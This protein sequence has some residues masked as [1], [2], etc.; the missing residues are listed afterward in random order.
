MNLN[1]FTHIYLL[2]IGGIGMS[3]LARYFMANNKI[4]AGYDRT[5]TPLTELLESEGA[6]IH[7]EDNINHISPDFLNTKD[8][9]IIYTPAIP[10]GH[11]EFN[12]FKKQKFILLKRS[13]V[14]G[15]ISRD[16][17]CIAIAGTHGKTTV[18]SMTAHILHQGKMGCNAFLGGIASNYNS[19]L[20][21]N[22]NSPNLVIEADE[23]DRS[24]LQLSPNLAVITSMDADHL[25]IYSD[26]KGLKKSFQEFADLI[27]PKGKLLIRKG[28]ENEIQTELNVY[29]Y[30][31]EDS[32]ADFRITD[33]RLIEGIYHFTIWGPSLR[34]EQVQLGMP[35]KLN[36]ENALAAA[37]LAYL[38]K[39]DSEV[40]KS[41]LASF[42]GVK[43]RMEYIIKRND[44][45]YL[46]DYA[47]HPEE[48]KASIQS[49]K[50][51]FPDKKVIGIFQPHLYSRT[52][53]F[54]DGFAESLAL[55]DQLILLEIYP[56]REEAIPGIN[57]Q[58]LL[59]KIPMK[60]KVL[61]QKDELI[62]YLKGT[63]PQVILSLG[64]G[65]IDRL[66]DN[67]KGA[68]K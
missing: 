52:R 20:I 18:S 31:I 57:S 7:F 53:D 41:S 13:Q 35:G 40:I 29:T 9:L 38:S 10:K 64:A 43:R 50:A 12:Y 28:L 22:E 34:I 4:V 39:E 19:N 25:D 42:R 21:L 27:Q 66:V 16:K 3:A 11:Q 56:A 49:V 65:D 33:L 61:L 5:P 55:L 47:H 23:Y 24:F 2:G 68:F 36:V 8:T 37:A 60:D 59:E 67:I 1:Q 51:L 63:S 17:Y 14:L 58:L 6:N 46:D 26:H 44:L 62:P 48:L 45:I 15:L 54:L 30:S 32:T